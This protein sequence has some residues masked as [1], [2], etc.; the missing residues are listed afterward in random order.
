MATPRERHLCS[1]LR[2]AGFSA[3]QVETLTRLFGS[4]AQMNFDLTLLKWAFAIGL[5]VLLS[6]NL[7]MLS[8]L[9]ETRIDLHNR[10]DDLRNH[11]AA[12][13]DSS[14]DM[15]RVVERLTRIETLI[16]HDLVPH[17]IR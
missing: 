14:L 1:E 6:I 5:A 11:Q 15:C 2:N 17:P 12:V 16:Q 7:W 13:N 9:T 10:L 3:E 8:D 4:A